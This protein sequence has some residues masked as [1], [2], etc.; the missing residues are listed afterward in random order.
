MQQFLEI[1]AIEFGNSL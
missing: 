1:S